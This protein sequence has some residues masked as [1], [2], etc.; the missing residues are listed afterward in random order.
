MTGSLEMEVEE[1]LRLA[2]RYLVEAVQYTLFAAAV[3]VIVFNLWNLLRKGHH[4][5]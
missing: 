3:L 1:N 5:G 4:H 2:V